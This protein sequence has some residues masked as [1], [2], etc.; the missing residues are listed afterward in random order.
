M[1]STVEA[2]KMGRAGARRAQG[3]TTGMTADVAS[4]A[5]CSTMT[6]GVASLAGCFTGPQF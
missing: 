2:R 1:L 5:T 4:L 6:A 3:P